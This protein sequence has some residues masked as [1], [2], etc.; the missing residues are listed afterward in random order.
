MMMK[1]YTNGKHNILARPMTNI[2]YHVQEDECE[3]EGLEGM[4]VEAGYFIVFDESNFAWFPKAVF[5]RD[6]KELTL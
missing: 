2:E 4:E 5:E 1:A 6:C 3:Y